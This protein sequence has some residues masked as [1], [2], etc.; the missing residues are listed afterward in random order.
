MFKDIEK[1]L[2]NVT[3]NGFDHKLMLCYSLDKHYDPV[4][5]KEYISVAA[6]CQ[7]MY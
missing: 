4:Y 2:E 1:P 7:C 3:N 5:T 6:F